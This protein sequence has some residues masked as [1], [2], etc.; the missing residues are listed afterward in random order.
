MTKIFEHI[1]KVGIKA[2]PEFQKKRLATHGLNVGLL[3]DHGC[4]YCSTVAVLGRNPAF[5]ATTGMTAA[6]GLD[7]QVALIDPETPTRAAEH[8]I[9]LKPEDT[10]MLATMTDPY[11]PVSQ[12]YGLGTKC[13]KAVLSNSQASLRILTKNAAVADDYELFANHKDRVMVGLSVTGPIENEHLVSL[14]EPNASSISDR[15]EAYRQ[16]KQMGL[17][18]HGML[19]P[20]L[21]GVASSALSI[22]EMMETVLDF[23]PEDIWLEPVNPR[24]GG[25]IKCKNEFLAAGYRDEGY[26]LEEIRDREIH[27]LYVE[28]LI[29]TATGVA[30]ELGCLEKL[31]ILVYGKPKD[32]CCDDAAV[33][34]L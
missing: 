28:E 3:C 1:R 22:R 19:C 2:S 18:T 9:K 29:D 27:H 31:K 30:R 24:G 25:L 13:A 10:V 32:F 26:L 15:L 17:R 21:P 11:S 4:K 8:A 12:K 16:A 7:A 20:L 34:W 5:R 14:L 23:E 33:I 6:E